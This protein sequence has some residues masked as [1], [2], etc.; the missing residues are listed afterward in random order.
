M[1]KAV[2]YAIGDD[3]VS[4]AGPLQT[5]AGHEAGSEAAVHAMKELFGA[6]T[7]EA[8][9]LVDATN[10]FNC[11]NCQAALHNI[12]K[13]CPSFSTILQ[14]TYHVPVRLFVVG[15]GEISST[16]GTTQGDS[17]A[18][19]MYALAMVLLIRRLRTEVPD[20]SQ[21]W[22]AD[23]ASAVGSL[24]SLLTWWRQLSSYGP[25]YGYFTNAIK[26]ILIVKPEHLTRAQ[27]LFADTNI[28]ITARGQRHLGAVLG[29]REFAEEYVAVKLQS[30]VSEVSA[31]AGIANSRPHAAYSAFTHGL[32][33]RWVYLMRTVPDISSFLK[34]LEDAIRLQLLP[35]ISRHPGCSADEWDLLSLPYR[36]GGL[37]L[38]NPMKVSDSQFDVSLLIT[39]SLK[40]EISN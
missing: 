22:F 30:W 13:I 7:S 11:V 9:L 14:N 36:F 24:S 29:S 40:V 4:A 1:S 33:G 6:A 31:L 39:A 2:L 10:A 17:L 16:V 25:A 3:I 32:I 28:Q 18:M 8:A 23:D 26:N 20:V 5:C 38:I 15:E 12:S 19:G 37:G 27:N 34:P 21:V 35:S